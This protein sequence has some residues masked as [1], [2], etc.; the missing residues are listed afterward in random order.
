[1]K[2]A[3]L[4]LALVAGCGS[5]ASAAFEDLG[6]GARPI[7]MGNAFAAVADDANTIYYNPA[8]LGQLKHPQ[9]TAGYGQLYMGLSDGSNIGNGFIGVTTPLRDGQWGTLGFGALNLSLTGAYEEDTFFLSYGRQVYG[10]LYAG[11][12]LKLLKQSFAS[13]AYTQ[14]DPLFTQHGRQASATSV[15]LGLLYRASPYIVL[16]GGLR[17][18]NDPSVGVAQGDKVP[19]ALVLG[20]A[21]YQRSFVLGGSLTKKDGDTDLALGGERWFYRHFV[22]GRGGFEFGSRNLRNLTMGLGARLGNAQVDYAFVLPLSGITNTSGS[23]RVSLTLRFGSVQAGPIALLEQEEILGPTSDNSEIAALRAEI[24]KH[25]E[26][27]DSYQRETDRLQG[28]IL[29]LETEI[30][31]LRSRTIAPSQLPAGVVVTSTTPAAAP[32]PSAEEQGLKQRIDRLEQE[33]QD[34]RKEMET[35]KPKPA[36]TSLST[37]AA[38]AQT[39][40]SQTAPPKFKRPGVYA[41]KEG[42]TLQS[43]AAYTLG[44]ADRWPE[45]YMANKERLKRGGAVTP[46]QNLIIP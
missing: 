28:R 1:M 44:D 25:Q 16:S 20:G 8:G 22:A 18:A 21:Y 33:L 9:L 29:E 35:R 26:E 37:P 41:V 10:S 7:S 23:H 17:D 4:L 13:D 43:I 19:H 14:A 27:Q 2:K 5:L 15:D 40:F 6:A 12:S 11:G 31:G 24:L 32:A 30:R 39:V 36:S 38:P 42:D 3:L 45:I 34:Q 46:G